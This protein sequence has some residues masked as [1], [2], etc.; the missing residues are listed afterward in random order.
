MKKKA[1][2]LTFSLLFLAQNLFAMTNLEYNLSQSRRIHDLMINHSEVPDGK[3]LEGEWSC[4]FFHARKDK[5]NKIYPYTSNFSKFEN[6]NEQD[7]TITG[8]GFSLNTYKETQH[9]FLGLDYYVS[10]SELSFKLIRKLKNSVVIL[11]SVSSTTIKD[12]NGNS[13]FK[14]QYNPFSDSFNRKEDYLT[15]YFAE[16]LRR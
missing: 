16:C 12:D 14:P 2:L 11:I 6:F 10:P 3:F 7:K 13:D 4:H 5:D 1:Y 15:D 8:F 9:G